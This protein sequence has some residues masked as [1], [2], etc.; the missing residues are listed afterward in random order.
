MTADATGD[1][2][3]APPRLWGGRFA[4]APSDAVAALSSSVAFDWRLAP[5]DLAASRAHARVLHGAGLLGADELT[6]MLA[7]LDS[8]KTEVATGTFWPSEFDEDVHTA[9][10]RGLVERLGS[11]PSDHVA[12][13]LLPLRSDAESDVRTLAKHLLREVDLGRELAP[14]TAPEGAGN[15]LNAA[16]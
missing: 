10:E 6:D 14:A 13:A 3:H 1:G 4:S 15:E 5:Y 7:A 12:A 8:L 11:L 16:A 9:L 2:G